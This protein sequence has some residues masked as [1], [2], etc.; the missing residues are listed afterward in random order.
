VKWFSQDGQS[1]ILN[2]V[3]WK[4]SEGLLIISFKIRINIHRPFFGKIRSLQLLKELMAIKTEQL[5]HVCNDLVNLLKNRLT[6]YDPN[7]VEL[8]GQQYFMGALSRLISL[9]KQIEAEEKPYNLDKQDLHFSI[10]Y[11]EGV[12]SLQV[13]VI[14]KEST[15]IMAECMELVKSSLV[16]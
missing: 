10:S 16:N 8:V 11:P 4:H 9:S 13:D 12:D 3:D 14:R 2:V 5:Q 1:N 7:L 6:D 15:K